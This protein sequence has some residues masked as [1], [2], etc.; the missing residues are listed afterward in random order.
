M[1]DFK[2]ERLF[3]APGDWFFVEISHGEERAWIARVLCFVFGQ[4]E[5]TVPHVRPITGDG[6]PSEDL[7]GLT[8]TQIVN[9][10]DAGPDGRL[11]LEVYRA[12][13]GPTKVL[14]P[15]EITELFEGL[16]KEVR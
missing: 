14:G 5:D 10:A 12:T 4:T 2:V 15:H 7:D 8:D 16:V 1:S 13:A 9:G 6:M 11:W 3:T